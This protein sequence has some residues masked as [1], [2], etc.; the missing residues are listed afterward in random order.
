ME[1]VTN[2]ALVIAVGIFITIAITSGILFVISAMRNVYE[3]V[4]ETDISLTSKFSEFDKFDNTQ[5]TGLDIAN[6]LNKYSQDEYKSYVSFTDFNYNGHDLTN[7]TWWTEN[8][9]ITDG[10]YAQKFQANRTINDNTG[11]V[12]IT[13]SKII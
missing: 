8:D 12:I 2:K 9:R 13:F 6:A 4:Y 5:V 11:K 10:T 7:A 3:D 1:S